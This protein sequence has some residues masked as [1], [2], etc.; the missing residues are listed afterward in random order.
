M[1]PERLPQE[2]SATDASQSVG[3]VQQGAWGAIRTALWGVGLAVLSNLGNILKQFRNF[4]E[5]INQLEQLFH[6]HPL[7]SVALIGGAI[8]LGNVLLFHFLYHK[9]NLRVRTTYKVLT[10]AGFLAIV[11][12]VLLTN[13]F[14]LRS[15]LQSPSQVQTELASTVE[16]VQDIDTG[17]YR[18]ATKG[19]PETWDTAQAVNAVIASGQYDP[20][21]IAKAFS[22]MESERTNG[23]F[24]IKTTNTPLFIRTEGASWVAVAYLE[25]LPRPD[26]WSDT[27]R[28][29]A[30][31]QAENTLLLL[32]SQQDRASGGWS[33]IPRYA[34]MHQR[35]YATTMA[36]WALTEALLSKDISKQTKERLGAPFEGGVAWLI[37]HY[38]SNVGWE[39]DPNFST[40][41]AFPGLTYQV[42][43]VL[44]R[45]QIVS[46]HNAFKNTEA[47]RDIKRQLRN[48]LHSAEVGDVSSVPTSDIM[49][50][51]YPCFMDF[52]AYPWLISTLPLLIADPD[53]PSE[54]HTFLN[55]LLEDEV[56]KANGLPHSLENAETWQVAENLFGISK[57]ID[58]RKT[59]R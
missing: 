37:S 44:E 5:F 38:V 9:L 31:S 54:S 22:Y 32:A 46:Q 40:G 20:A 10:L 29:T 45:A 24:E 42:L 53:V 59:T 3:Q 43:F 49:V 33:P 28:T 17:A 39:E 14:S 8:A 34:A 35:T 18:N 55:R 52:A 11:S 12:A 57:F 13:W 21:R 25:A 27:Q 19:I 1:N 48:V 41:R 51:E 50:G 26:L 30:I 4:A 2:L 58:S 16:A 23:G 56:G 47:Y 7:I 6:E 15:L 36:V